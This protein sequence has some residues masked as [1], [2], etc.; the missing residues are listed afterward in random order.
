MAIFTPS[1]SLYF[2]KYDVFMVPPYILVVADHK[3]RGGLL[4]R[5]TSPL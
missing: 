4:P 1:S 3:Q 5:Y 2:A